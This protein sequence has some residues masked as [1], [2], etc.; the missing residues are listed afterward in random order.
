MAERRAR[1]RARITIREIVDQ[2]DPAFRAAH[3]LLRS[4]FHRAEML[5]MSDWRNAMRE[6][7]ARLWTDVNWHLLVA[8]RNRVV[9]AACSGSYLGN[10][11]VGIV[12]YIAVRTAARSAG[13]GP[14]MRRA[15]R[16]RF[17]ADARLVGHERLH[18]IV[19]EVREDNPWLRHLVSREGAVALDFPYFQPSLG[20]SRKAVPLVLYYQPLDR[21]SSS[22]SAER[23]RKL[24]Y[25]MWRRAYRVPRPLQDPAFRR[26]LRALAGRRRVGQRR[27]PSRAAT[28]ASTRKRA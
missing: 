22:L 5:P 19:G 2:H 6:R 24:L 14:R 20:G 1:A 4:S 12:G 8:E 3:E 17:E 15:L 28:R 13:L 21:A 26:M 7:Q 10:F 27:L 16:R 9:V 23:V 25:T 11:N 18:A